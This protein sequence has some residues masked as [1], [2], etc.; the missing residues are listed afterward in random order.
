MEKA[1]DAMEKQ[2]KVDTFLMDKRPFHIHSIANIIRDKVQNF[3]LGEGLGNPELAKT[4]EGYIK[5]AT[6]GN[7]QERKNFKEFLKTM[8]LGELELTPN[9]VISF[10]QRK[11]LVDLVIPFYDP[12]LMSEQDKFETLLYKYGGTDENGYHTGFHQFRM[13]NSCYHGA[14]L[15]ESGKLKNTWYEYSGEQIHQIYGQENFELS[16]NDKVDIIVQRI[17][18]NIYGLGCID[19][20]AYSNVNEIGVSNDGEYIYC[21]DEE[22]IHLSFLSMKESEMMIVQNRSIS[23]DSKIGQLCSSTPEVN[24]CRADNARIIATQPPFS[25]SRNLCIR[26]FNKRN[27]CYQDIIQDKKQRLLIAALIKSGAKIC[28]QGS[29]GSGKT[30]T[31]QALLE[32]MDDSLHIGTVE[33]YFE[34]HN[35][36]KYPNKRIVEVQVLP[37]KSLLDTA[38][39]LFRTSIDVASV[40]EARTGDAVFGFLQLAQAINQSALFTCHIASPEDTIPRLKNMLLSTGVYFS[41]QSAVADI[42]NYV[43]IIFQHE[44][45]GKERRITKIVEI[46]PQTGLFSETE[47]NQETNLEELQKLSFIQQIQQDTSYMYRLNTL[48]EFE[49]GKYVFKNYPSKRMI[50][51]AEKGGVAFELME[52][53][54]SLIK[55]ELQPKEKTKSGEV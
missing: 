49:E 22:K 34:Q 39:A 2:T 10:E 26:I 41:E 12:F 19:I 38:A 40:G 37:E 11:E 7:L 9:V 45:V 18:E 13:K 25:S 51:K 53:L 52:E 20:L 55:E 6:N 14:G 54:L 8:F 1:C 17:Y 16:F 27:T 32:L 43:N 50:Q 15:T 3:I 23:F 30:T 44:I 47:L 24:C 28:L 35:A 36:L 5:K 31:M 4:I 46:I 33:D 29:L 48:M 21:W 42:V